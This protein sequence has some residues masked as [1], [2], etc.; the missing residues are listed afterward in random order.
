MKLL[1]PP[2]HSASSFPV[3][4]MWDL[5]HEIPMSRHCLSL[6]ASRRLI[7]HSIPAHGVWDPVVSFRVDVILASLSLGSRTWSLGMLSCRARHI[8]A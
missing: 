4:P 1:G 5:S 3:I 2:V 6:S 7:S 8:Y